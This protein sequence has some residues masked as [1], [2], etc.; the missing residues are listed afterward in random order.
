[1]LANIQFS[2]AL[3][4]SKIKI[5]RTVVSS[6]VLHGRQTWAL[7]IRTEQIDLS[8]NTSDFYSGLAQ[9]E[10]RLGHRLY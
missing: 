8:D 1:M 10:S 3:Y 7:T 5:Y 6:V 9:F 2:S 4:K